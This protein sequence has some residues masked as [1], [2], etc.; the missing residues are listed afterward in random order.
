MNLPR[1]FRALFRRSKLD[2]DMDAELRF[3]IEEQTRANLAAGMSPD[4][5]AL[6][7]RKQFGWRERIREE[8]RDQ[9]GITD[10]ET[11]I[12][13]IQF[14]VRMLRRS[15]GFTFIAV[16]TLALGIGLNTSM[17]SVVNRVLFRPLSYPDAGQLVRVFGTSPQSRNMIFTAPYA[18][19]LRA[20][21]HG[22]ASMGSYL[23]WSGTLTEPDRP[24]EHL[25]TLRVSKDFLPTL[26]VQPQLGRWFTA[27]E[28]RPGSN[29]VILSYGTWMHFFSGDR[30]IIGRTISIQSTPV[31][32]VGVMPEH[33]DAP[34][35]FGPVGLLRPL[36][37]TADE[38]TDRQQRGINL[39]GRLAPGASARETESRLRA[40]AAR[41]AEEFPA[42]NKQ[43]SVRLVGLHASGTPDAARSLTLFVLGLSG[44]VL[45]IACANLANLQLVRATARSRENAIRLALGAS[46]ANLMRPLVIESLI[47]AIVGGAAGILIAT[48]CNAWIS[49]RAILFGTTHLD[50]P[51]DVR[52]LAFALVVT[53]LTGLLF[54][55][56]PGWF[57]SRARVGEALKQQSRGAT[58]GRGHGF[59][60]Q[61]L[62]VGEFALA[63]VLLAGAGFFLSAISRFVTRDP[64]WN[65]RDLAFGSVALSPAHYT[66][67]IKT[68]AFYRELRDRLAVAPGVEGVAVGWTLPMFTFLSTRPIAVDGRAPAANERVPVTFV[69]AVLPGYF[70]TLQIPL[71]E[72]RLFEDRDDR[73]DGP[74]VAIINETMARTLWPGQGALGK[75][76]GRTDAANPGWM[77]IVGVV[78]D[79]GFAQNL[80]APQT[81][82]QVFRPFSQEPWGYAG[83][84]IRTRGAAESMV[85]L[86][87][88][89]V[90]GIDAEIA[91][92]SPTTVRQ[93]MQ[94]SMASFSLIVRL[95]AGF[96]LLGLFL[97]ALGIYGVIAQTVAQRTQ[98]IGVRLALGAQVRD[99]LW[100]VLRRGLWLT[101]F[102]A[103]VGVIGAFAIGRLLSIVS[104]EMRPPTMAITG[105]VTLALVIVSIIA[106]FLPASRATRVNR[107]IALR[108]E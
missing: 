20:A 14:A 50:L 56:A 31:T 52:V 90:T 95:L 42:E 108:A 19:E 64:G 101:T 22:F 103:I 24:A 96:A 72:G 40:V 46:R 44:F 65:T 37:L 83:I 35:V 106:S 54:G 75:R 74:A 4:E 87:R 67:G 68:H 7:A 77:E 48:W 8:A 91:V 104:P 39:I 41:L 36:A 49:A 57:A 34:L 79:V 63:L 92:D 98:E 33:F 53:L 15:P 23:V 18:D 80:G 78:R 29:V 21:N 93:A 66:D 27:E 28:D 43:T 1:I 38:M 84:A 102:G 59:L 25:M 81:R 17:F 16:V 5:A 69:N 12:K 47:L 9:R 97:A 60:R 26:G 107:M 55:T 11:Y 30:N 61:T 89:T 94:Q 71:V 82:L 32:V 70:E 62:V 6:A 86:L 73:P 99:V 10:M 105:L 3:H 13:E 51:L 85:E 76:I 58:S 88:R 100:M 45:L 2:D